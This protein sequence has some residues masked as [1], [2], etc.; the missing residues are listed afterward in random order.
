LPT[1]YLEEME[2]EFSENDELVKSSGYGGIQFS[3]V[4]KIIDD[5]FKSEKKLAPLEG[6]IKSID[7]YLDK[8]N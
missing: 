7:D 4:R 5:H 1:D 3:S 2:M 8:N 6:V